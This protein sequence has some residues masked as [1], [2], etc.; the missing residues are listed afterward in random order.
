MVFR[1]S[2]LITYWFIEFTRFDSFCDDV[3]SFSGLGDYIHLPLKTYSQG[4]ESRLL[5]YSY[6]CYSI[7]LPWMR[8]LVPVISHFRESSGTDV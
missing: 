6:R 8:V 5:F 7:V 1:L 3:L 2:K 4:M